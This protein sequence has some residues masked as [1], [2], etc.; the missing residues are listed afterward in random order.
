MSDAYNTQIHRVAELK[1]DTKPLIEKRAEEKVF[2]TN[3]VPTKT[4]T[5][6]VDNNAKVVVTNTLSKDNV[7]NSVSNLIST[8]T[9]K[10][11]KVTNDSLNSSAKITTN[12]N[13]VPID[14]TENFGTNYSSPG[15]K[16]PTMFEPELKEL[17]NIIQ[18]VGLTTVRTEKPLSRLNENRLSVS[19]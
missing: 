11:V 16:K 5:N 13:E 4:V 7:S 3:Q 2:Q 18:K 8:V 14:V 9:N 19:S 10:N 1:S 6:I 17:T 15:T 12:V